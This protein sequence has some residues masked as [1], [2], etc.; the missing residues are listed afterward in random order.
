MR[1][2]S[3]SKNI[4]P[5]SEFKSRAAHH[6]RRLAK[7][8]D[9]IIITQKGKAAGVLLSPEAFDE[10]TERLRFAEA[11][12]S[13]LADVEQGRVISHDSLVAET[14]ARYGTKKSK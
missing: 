8:K 4:I 12:Q 2:L 11:V 7:T 5:V 14:K 9:A 13:G 6:L 3:V 10:L 1:N